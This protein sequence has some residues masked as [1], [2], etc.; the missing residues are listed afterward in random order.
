[1]K[2]IHTQDGTPVNP[3]AIRT[4]TL[5]KATGHWLQVV[6]ATSSFRLT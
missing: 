1:M 6:G 4:I 5:D 2:W 3:E